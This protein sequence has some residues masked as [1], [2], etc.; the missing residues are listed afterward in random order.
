MVPPSFSLSILRGPADLLQALG[1]SSA[2][3]IL[4]GPYE[5]VLF[6]LGLLLAAL[7]SLAPRWLG[8]G[9]TLWARYVGAAWLGMALASLSGANPSWLTLS[10]GIF[11]VSVGLIVVWGIPVW[12]RWFEAHQDSPYRSTPRW[13]V[14][15]YETRH[16]GAWGVPAIAFGSALIGGTALHALLAGIVTTA[17]I[18]REVRDEVSLQRHGQPSGMVPIL[19]P[20]HRRVFGKRRVEDGPLIVTFNASVR[21][22]SIT[23]EVSSSG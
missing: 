9:R 17:V 7:A 3:S 18:A 15:V 10:T 2:D 5:I 14:A 19:L 4:S 11:L 1:A 8:W 12:E 6:V 16:H 20:L 21:S 22:D 13:L 23:R